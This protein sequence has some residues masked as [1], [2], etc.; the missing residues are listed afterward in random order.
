MFFIALLPVLI[1]RDFTPPNEL[2]YVSI[3]MEAFNDGHFFTFS[4]HGELYADK[5]PM[6]FW[7]IMLVK[8]LSGSYSMFGISLFSILPAIGMAAI[9]CKWTAKE[10]SEDDQLLA[11]GMLM[12]TIIYI[13]SAL[14]LRMDMLMSIFTTLSL[15]HFYKAYKGSGKSID[16]TL[17]FVYAFLGLFTKGPMGLLV[18]LLSILLFLARERK[19]KDVGRYLTP[20]DS[21]GFLIACIL[22]FAM[23]YIEGGN[24]YLYDLTVR[25]TV[26][27][28]VN[29]FAHKKPFY[30]YLQGM[31]GTFMPWSFVYIFAFILS[32][33]RDRKSSTIEKMFS[34]VIIATFGFLSIASGKL[35]IYLIPIYP[36][37][38]FYA[39]LVLRDYKKTRFYQYTL[40]LPTLVLSLIPVVYYFFDKKGE[41]PIADDG[42]LYAGLCFTALFGIYALVNLV[43][44]QY[45]KTIWSIVIGFFLIL[46]TA[47]FRIDAINS[48]IGLKNV[49]MA[50]EKIK[51]ELNLDGYYVYGYEVGR[52]ADAYLGERVVGLDRVEELE[53][54][55]NDILFIREKKTRREKKVRDA[56]TELGFERVW[57]EGKFHMYIIQK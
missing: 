6:Y 32:F 43:K 28:G 57:D 47:S 23:V 25:Q 24:D 53:D 34:S 39:M 45:S 2:K 30:Y 44:K 12:S 7:V 19:I 48:L 31:W 42:I 40:A 35:E 21:I 26:G 51:N 55:S 8:K 41:I 16:K 4:N 18:P 36:F 20:K 49:A 50:G 11:T 15:Y 33:K 13:G 17:I 46:I 54:L 27:R 14:V 5:P 10:L 9:M 52:N 38:A 22:W 29:S 37:V 56:L 3:V 1:F